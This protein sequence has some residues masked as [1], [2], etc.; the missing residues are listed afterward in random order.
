MD[1]VVAVAQKFRPGCSQFLRIRS[2][3]QEGDEEVGMPKFARII[4]FNTFLKNIY[5]SN[6]MVNVCTKFTFDLHFLIYIV[7]SYV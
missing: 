1:A 4:N 6:V 2:E 3:E 5:T 7:F